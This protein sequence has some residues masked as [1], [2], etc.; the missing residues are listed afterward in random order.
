MN[1]ATPASMVQEMERATPGPDARRETLRL[2][3]RG[4]ALAMYQAELCKN[5]LL[6]MYPELEISIQVIQSLGDLVR[7]RPL[8]QVGQQGIFTK[9]LEYA[10]R[11]G[12]IDV[13]VHSAKDL[14]STLDPAFT[15]AATP[16]REDPHDCLITADGR[17]LQDLPFGARVGTG[18]PRRI[19]QLRMVRPDLRFEP[20]RGNVDTRRRTVLERR[21]DAVVLAAAGLRR[22]GLFDEHISLLPLELCLPQAGQGI[23]ALETRADDQ[24]AITLLAAID[25]SAAAARLQAERAVLAGLA[26]GCQA[27]V[28]AHATIDEQETLRVR[29]LVAALDGS[30][31]LAA[32]AEGRAADAEA[33]GH[34]VAHLLRA[35]GADRILHD[36]REDE[37]P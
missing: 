3:T 6:A 5:L 27:P 9:Q 11:D 12:S 17:T 15:I 22:L 25:E 30:A 36:A 13:A 23:L 31:T 32:E 4:S 2:G 8:E 21:L 28:A 16:P 37:Q 18:S 29:G 20:I 26:A 34:Q 7:D 19:A 24:H 1:A 10:L 35:Q 14:P 33:L